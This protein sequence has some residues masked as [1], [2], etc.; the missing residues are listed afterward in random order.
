MTTAT[1]LPARLGRC[2]E[3]LPGTESHG[4]P[5]D[6]MKALEGLLGIG[7]SDTPLMLRMTAIEAACGVSSG[8]LLPTAV[9]SAQVA[10]EG[11][12]WI[13]GAFVQQ[14]AKEALDALALPD[15]QT[16]LAF[17]GSMRRVARGIH[18]LLGLREL[19]P[20]LRQGSMGAVGL[21]HGRLGI[22]KCLGRFRTRL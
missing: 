15:Y 18:G 5:I 6:R 3:T 4:T 10:G 8:A 1:P 16:A 2:E 20:G 9:G 22:I 19:R 13:L 7:P 14:H 11:Q 17:L 21:A 12:V